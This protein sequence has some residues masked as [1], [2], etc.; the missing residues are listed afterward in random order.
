LAV[1]A[2]YHLNRPD[3][4]TVEMRIY[5]VRCAVERKRDRR[6]KELII[7][8]A[9]LTLASLDKDEQSSFDVWSEL[10]V[11]RRW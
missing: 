7:N 8:G 11:M 10:R 2:I 6:A 1:K 9:N 3:A 5:H 4:S